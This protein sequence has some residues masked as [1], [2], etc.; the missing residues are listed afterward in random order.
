MNEVVDNPAQGR[1]E[2][3]VGG[4]VAFATYRRE[5]GRLVIPYV[6]A[7]AALRGTGA[8]GRLMEGVLAV[9]RAQALKVTPIC[10]YAAAYIRR[11]KQHHD[12]LA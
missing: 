12:L 10:G 7:P 11:H 5:P 3:D 1:F 2:L 4:Q 8:A 6:E 9:A